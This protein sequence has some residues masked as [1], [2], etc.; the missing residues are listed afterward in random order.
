MISL[1]QEESI[2]R[3]AYIPEHIPRLMVGI[4]R[5]EPFLLEEYLCLAKDDWLIFIGYPLE[6][7]FEEDK[8]LAALERARRK[9]RPLSTSFIAPALPQAWV[10]NTRNR[11]SDDYYR[12]GLESAEI[13]KNMR[14]I[15][16]KA[17]RT[18][19][20]EQSRSLSAEHEALTREF[21][22]RAQL[23]P[24]IREL[25]LRMP[26]YVAHSG[27][28]IALSARDLEGRLAAFFIIESGAARFAVYVVGCFSRNNYVPHASD[29]LFHEM[30]RLA[31]ENGK[32]YIHLGLG[33]NEGLRRFK[34]KW[35]GI[36]FLPYH[37]AEW[38]KAPQGPI[39]WLRS[40]QQKLT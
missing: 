5:G 11:E 9:F 18:L 1:G 36:P 12:L 10:S 2:L 20:V 17:S 19:I 25:Y 34:A 8:F 15:V 37:F 33:V 28:S 14:R 13:G 38:G 26:D 29:V 7:A 40:L 21:L 35:G 30:I 32:E 24:R 22:G 4:S 16:E 31:K 6:T 39:S 3:Q 27:T 23:P